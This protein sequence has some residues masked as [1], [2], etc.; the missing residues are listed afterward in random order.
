WNEPKSKKPNRTIC[1]MD[2]LT[3]FLDRSLLSSK[4]SSITFICMKLLDDIFK[5]LPPDLKWIY[6]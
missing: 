4:V 1:R 3:V 6:K 2:R 5:K